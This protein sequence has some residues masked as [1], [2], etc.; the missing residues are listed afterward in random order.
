MQISIYELRSLFLL[1]FHRVHEAMVHFKAAQYVWQFNISF[2]IIL[3]IFNSIKVKKWD[4]LST[5]DQSN[6][7][8]RLS[9]PLIHKQKVKKIAGKKKWLFLQLKD[10]ESITFYKWNA[11]NACEWKRMTRSST[12][13]GFFFFYVLRKIK[14]SCLNILNTVQVHLIL[15]LYFFTLFFALVYFYLQFCMDLC[16]NCEQMAKSTTLV[17]G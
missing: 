10:T 13:L 6:H 12:F 14:Y 7:Y 11:T 17:N 9:N 16:A 1:W 3:T 8:S 15:N 4:I 5:D 2:S